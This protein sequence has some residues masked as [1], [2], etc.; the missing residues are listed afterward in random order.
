[1]KI[2]ILTLFPETLKSFFSESIV[3]RSIEKS[4]VEIEIV[5]IRDFARDS[6]GSVDDKPYGGGAGMVMRID[7]IADA[8]GKSQVRS[9]KS[10]VKEKIILTSPRGAVWSQR[11]A[12]EYSS[13]DH[14]V[15]I[16]GHYEG[17]DERISELVDEEISLGDFVMTGGEITAAAIVDS[18]VRLLPGAI[19]KESP[20]EESFSEVS[21]TL[22]NEII[23]SD[24]TI[25]SLLERNVETV[26]LLE[27]PQYTR[28][29]EFNGKK[30]PAVLLSGNHKE[31]EK[32]RIQMAYEETKK[33]RPDLL[34]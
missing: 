16:C 11:K 34:K 5:N 26:R 20:E 22:L 29:E 1:M 3:K 25:Q 4:A 23:G 27:Y 32:W 24:E 17:I 28:P 12:K 30:V 13:L 31:I 19:K 6:Y 21:V 10:E 9:H 7:V 14:I 2:S 15:I 33:R 18:V 8:I